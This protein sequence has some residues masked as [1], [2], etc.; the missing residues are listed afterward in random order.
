MVSRDTS[1]VTVRIA[2]KELVGHECFSV[3]DEVVRAA[4][5]VEAPMEERAT[6]V[7]VWATLL[8]S[9]AARR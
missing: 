9:V 5:V 6:T 4:V 2:P 7:V 8:G 3:V 1:R